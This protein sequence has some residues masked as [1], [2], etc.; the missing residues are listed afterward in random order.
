MGGAAKCMEEEGEAWAEIG[1][2]IGFFK[3]MYAESS[4]EKRELLMKEMYEYMED[5]S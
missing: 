3:K 4:H 2:M 1:P 5:F